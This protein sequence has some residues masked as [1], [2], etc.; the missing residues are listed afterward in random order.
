MDF[1][2]LFLKIYPIQFVISLPLC[3]KLTIGQLLLFFLCNFSSIFEYVLG[4]VV[5]NHPLLVTDRYILANAQGAFAILCLICSDLLNCLKVIF[6]K[7]FRTKVTICHC[8]HACYVWPPQIF[9]VQAKTS[10]VRPVFPDYLS[11]S[12]DYASTNHFGSYVN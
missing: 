11:I 3:I 5:T 8:F 10:T 4:I 2:L 12:Y 6:T 7:H 1:V 9:K